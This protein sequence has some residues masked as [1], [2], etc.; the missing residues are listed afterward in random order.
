ML[1]DTGHEISYEYDGNFELSN[2]SKIFSQVNEGNNIGK[3]GIETINLLY[4]HS[5]IVYC[6]IHPCWF[7][8]IKQIIYYYHFFTARC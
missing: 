8:Q 6:T 7:N 3:I 4:A 1:H 2:I 5:H